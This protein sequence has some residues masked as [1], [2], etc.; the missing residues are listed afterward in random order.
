MAMTI[1]IWDALSAKA[2]A[3]VTAS[4]TVT[5]HESMQPQMSFEQWDNEIKHVIVTIF[6]QLKNTATS[7]PSWAGDGDGDGYDAWKTLSACS[8]KGVPLSQDEMQEIFGGM[9]YM[10]IFRLW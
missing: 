5:A 3:K 2:Q 10:D 8:G 1:G 7:T 4:E 6:G 9:T